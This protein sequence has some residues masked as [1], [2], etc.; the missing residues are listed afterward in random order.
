MEAI[1]NVEASAIVGLILLC[2]PRMLVEIALSPDELNSLCIINA[3]A[4]VNPKRWQKRLVRRYCRFPA[5]LSRHGVTI[6]ACLIPSCS[7]HLA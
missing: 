2:V 3:H 7:S 5:E 6:L 4:P 1:D